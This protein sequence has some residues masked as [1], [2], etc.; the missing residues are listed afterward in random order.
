MIARTVRAAERP[1]VR[2]SAFA[3]AL[4]AGLL[5]TGCSGSPA[6]GSGTPATSETA[7]AAQTASE[8][9]G[10]HDGWAK[11]GSGMTAVFGTL[12]NHGEADRTLVSASS[13]IAGAVELHETV[14]TGTSATMQEKEG[15]F[16]IPA[17]GSVALEPGGN[18]IMFMDMSEDLLP[19]D[20]VP[21]TLRFDDGSEL[22]LTVLAKDVASGEENYAGSGGEHAGHGDDS[23]GDGSHG[24]ADAGH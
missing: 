17:G 24:D 9:V 11:S 5:L 18:H 23:H 20:E 21:L 2:A 4:V 13:R 12:D 1:A 3:A 15:G 22:T 7:E 14:G 8:A 16:V 19:G 10:L 6:A